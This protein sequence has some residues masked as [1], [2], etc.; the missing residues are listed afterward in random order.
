MNEKVEKIKNKV[1]RR[2][3]SR[4]LTKKEVLHEFRKLV[5]KES[6]CFWVRINEKENCIEMLWKQMF[7]F[8]LFNRMLIDAK[9]N[10]AAIQDILIIAQEFKIKET[11]ET[12]IRQIR[13]FVKIFM[14]HKK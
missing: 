11:D 6:D 12:E 13:Q 2:K 7:Q 1:E 5:R 4:F 14:G 3:N 8:E 10:T 9:V